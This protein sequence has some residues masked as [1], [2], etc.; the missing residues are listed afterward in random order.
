MRVTNFSGPSSHHGYH[1]SHSQITRPLNFIH[2]TEIKGE[3]A[4]QGMVQHA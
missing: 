3:K 1:R 4:H 2:K